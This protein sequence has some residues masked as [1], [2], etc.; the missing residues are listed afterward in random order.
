MTVL[1]GDLHAC[2]RRSPSSFTGLLSN[3]YTPLPVCVCVPPTVN[4]RQRTPS[5]YVNWTCSPRINDTI[6]T[7]IKWPATLSSREGDKWRTLENYK[8]LARIFHAS[9]DLFPLHGNKAEEAGKFWIFLIWLLEWQC[10]KVCVCVCV[11][12]VTRTVR[13][14][15]N[16]SLC[17]SSLVTKAQVL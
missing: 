3:R 15:V 5:V 1:S 12:T 13:L 2:A 11:A 7:A 9:S 17:L 6:N 10:F 8:M 14:A 16:V 4:L